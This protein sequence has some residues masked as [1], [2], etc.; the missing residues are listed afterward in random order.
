MS[1]F[2][3]DCREWDTQI[4]L[5]G[6]TLVKGSFLGGNLYTPGAQ[7]LYPEAAPCRQPEPSWQKGQVLR[8]AP[9]KAGR[10]AISLLRHGLDTPCC[11]PARTGGRDLL[12]AVWTFLRGACLEPRRIPPGTMLTLI[13]TSHP[14]PRQQEQSRYLRSP[15]G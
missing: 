12:S 10:R 7:H 6:P 2:T 4:H 11:F 3:W 5:P 9:C 15:L 8:V 1:V 14:G 13:S